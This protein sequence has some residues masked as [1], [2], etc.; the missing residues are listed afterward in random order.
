MTSRASGLSRRQ[1]ALMSASGLAPLVFGG[2]CQALG[3]AIAVSDGRLAFRPATPAPSGPALASGRLG[4]ESGRDAVVHVPA[5]PAPGPLPL[6]VFL[7][8]AGGSGENVI[9]RLG[10]DL[11]TARLV[12][13]APDSRGATWDAIRSGFGPD[14]AFLD[15][16]LA[17]VCERIAID[18]A[19]IVIGGFSDGASYALSL[20][21]INGD[22][23]QRIVAFSPG[24]IVPGPDHGKPRIF[25][26]HGTADPI[27][28]IADTSRRLVPALTKLGYD[29]TFREFAGGHEIPPDI[30]K[31]ALASM[32]G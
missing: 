20:G 15:R 29:V 7:H 22:L 28:P 2:A 6:F 11:E 9:K 24:F 13:V 25:V 3:R 18:P 32:A 8:G 17:R 27:L 26:S 21:V 14:V 23:F 30:A 5:S 31:D 1:F 10:P 16:V 4:L 12:V 19:R